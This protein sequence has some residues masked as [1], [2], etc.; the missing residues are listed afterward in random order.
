VPVRVLAAG[1]ANKVQAL[2]GALQ[3][4]K[5]TVLITDEYTARDLLKLA[6]RG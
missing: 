1:G 5:P 6:G 2:A 3:M 4:V